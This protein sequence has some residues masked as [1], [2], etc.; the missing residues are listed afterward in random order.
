MGSLLTIGVPVFNGERYLA[1]ALA[2]IRAQTFTDFEVVIGDN[3]STDRTPEIAAEFAAADS[4][5]RYV[6]RERNIGLVPNFNQLFTDTDSEFFAWHAA[7]DLTDPEF[8]GACVQLLQANPD[9]AAATTEILLMDSAGEV[10]GPDPEPIRGDHPDRVVRFIELAGF[11]HYA[12]FTYGVYRRSMMER[13]RLMLPFFWTSDRLFLAELA[14]QG[15]LLRDPRRLF[16]VRQHTE[17]VT[18]GGR[19]NFYAGLSAPQRGTT[20]RYARE[21]RKAIELADL[22]PA[23]RARLRRALRWWQLRH[24]HRLVRS[25]AGALVSAG[26]RALRRS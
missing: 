21:L 6:R 2:G 26:A 10:I 18:L 3:G 1:T 8:Y 14:L 13:T 23:E 19:A 20:L 25:A 4:R 22:P 9:A 7:D 12:Q 11:N 24:A 5:F 17:R 15:R 16:F